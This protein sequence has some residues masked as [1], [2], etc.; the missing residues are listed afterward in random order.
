V[1]NGERLEA[2]FI[3]DF[4]AGE[5]S[6]DDAC[7]DPFKQQDAAGQGPPNDDGGEAERGDGP[8]PPSDDDEGP[9]NLPSKGMDVDNP[10]PPYG[11]SPAAFV[12]RKTR[13][14]FLKSLSSKG[15]YEFL[16]K[17]LKG[18]LNFKDI[19]GLPAWA[20]WSFSQWFLPESFYSIAGFELAVTDI[21]AV[22]TSAKSLSPTLI[23]AIGLVLREIQWARALDT[24]ARAEG[25]PEWVNN[26]FL[27]RESEARV[28]SIAE[29]L[30]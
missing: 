15:S 14:P 20:S 18:S 2:E 1:E 9:V 23:L 29:R 19:D 27:S 28:L 6:E 25:T 5:D 10:N 26:D 24:D 17:K 7:P 12:L 30:L 4:N 11:T 3:K 13:I 8:V 22:A 21:G 16:L